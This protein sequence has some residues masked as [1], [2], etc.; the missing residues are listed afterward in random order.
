ME[1]REPDAHALVHVHGER[2]DAVRGGAQTVDMG[3]HVGGV[4]CLRARPARPRTPR[5]RLPRECPPGAL[6]D[7]PRC[8]LPRPPRTPRRPARTSRA[9]AR[10][11]SPRPS[12]PPGRAAPAGRRRRPP[13]RCARGRRGRP[14]AH[15]TAARA[16][17][18]TRV[19]PEPSRSGVPSVW[20]TC[21]LPVQNSS[22]S[23]STSLRSWAISASPLRTSATR[24]TKAPRLFGRW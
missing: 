11:A 21:P 7:A 17:R 9:P 12:P 4:D 1:L 6:P 16:S 3:A 20:A 24:P 14:G 8:G 23:P 19:R 18:G 5:R 10:R 2:D 15:G 22:T 13:R